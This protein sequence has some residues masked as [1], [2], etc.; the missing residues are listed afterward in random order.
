MYA[1]NNFGDQKPEQVLKRPRLH[2][3]CRNMTLLKNPCRNVTRISLIDQGF[4][5]L[6]PQ[7]PEIKS[8]IPYNN[9]LSIPYKILI[10][11]LY[12]IPTLW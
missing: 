5:T 1:C 11:S 7:N 8:Q 9:S 2:L 6:V 12:E 10:Q 4:P 3:A